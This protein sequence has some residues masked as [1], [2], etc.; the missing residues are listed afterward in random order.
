MLIQHFIVHRQ[1]LPA[2]D[3]F[4]KLPNSVSKT[5]DD[6]MKLFKSSHIRREKLTS[7]IEM[8]TEEHEYY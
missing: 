8:A 2:K 7:I 5:V 3:G 4:L 1:V 6:V